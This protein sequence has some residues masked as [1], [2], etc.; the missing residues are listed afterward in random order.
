MG[1]AFVGAAAFLILVLPVNWTAFFIY[2]AWYILQLVLYV[3]IPGGYHEG[4]PLKDDNNR[5]L[6]YKCN[7]LIAF[8]V[9]LVI[10]FFGDRF[11]P[12][13]KMSLLA[14]NFLEL[15]WIT[16]IFSF[17]FAFYLFIKGQYS[18]KKVTMGNFP[19]DLWFGVELNPLHYDP[20][21]F[22]IKFFSESRPGL[23]WWVL[24]NFS[25]AAKQYGDLGYVNTPMLIVCLF[26]F[27][28]ILDYFVLEN[29]IVT[30]WDI[31]Q[32]RFGWMLLWG[33]YV[34]VPYYYVIQCWYIY[35]NP[36]ENPFWYNFL[37]I[38]VF[39]AGYLVFRGAN[40][41]KHY[42]KINPKGPIW[43]K[44]PRV[45]VTKT[46]SKL[47]ISGWWALSRHPNYLGD[48]ILAFSWGMPAAFN[49]FIPGFE[50]YIPYLYFFFMVGLLLHRFARDDERCAEKYGEDWVS[51]SKIVKYKLIPYVF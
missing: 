33:D 6:R 43:G 35:F 16:N 44:P 5:K 46:G 20:L 1:V 45:I 8:I 15:L 34:W 27:L 14:D 18:T 41:Q 37:C 49:G 40:R 4:L 21:G 47:L 28:Y 10:F 25:I 39:C 7:G 3:A 29:F 13:W 11:I 42:F 48:W 32:E 51:Y 22:D 19:D 31:F 30:T 24:I 50:S 2:A 26:H 17:V 38:L 36:R 9:S 12:G 23:T